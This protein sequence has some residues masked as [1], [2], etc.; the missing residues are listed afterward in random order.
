MVST[1][2]VRDPDGKEVDRVPRVTALTVL[3]YLH[4]YGYKYE[5][6]DTLINMHTQVHT[7]M[8]TLI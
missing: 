2:P 8:R 7:H 4:A 5:L 1:A 3:W 6:V